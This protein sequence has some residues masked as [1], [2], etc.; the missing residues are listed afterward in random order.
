MQ[1]ATLPTFNV[2]K[3]SLLIFIPFALLQ[4]V[5]TVILTFG[6]QSLPRAMALFIWFA[7]SAAV[8]TSLVGAHQ[9]RW[10]HFLYLQ[11]LACGYLFLV[12]AAIVLKTDQVLTATIVGTT[13]LAVAL[14]YASGCVGFWFSLLLKRG[15]R[16]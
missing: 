3:W 1:N 10:P 13:S 6:D 11:A 5:L 7:C 2:L 4:A 15:L 9:V 12:T 8:G 14:F 16:A